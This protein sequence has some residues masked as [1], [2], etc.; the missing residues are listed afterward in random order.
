MIRSLPRP[1]R[2]LGLALAAAVAIAS[3]ATGAS[4]IPA[5]PSSAASAA[6]ASPVAVSPVQPSSAP[7]PAAGAAMVSIQGFAFHAKALTVKVGEPV[8]W[9]NH[10]GATHTVTFD[11]GGVDSGRLATDGTFTHAFTSAGS[12]SY[13]CAIHTSMTGTI[14]VTP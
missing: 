11:A 13:H 9:T 1:G 4:T 6:P 7:S 8:T 5:G 14:T 2:P 3:C 10:D 12:F